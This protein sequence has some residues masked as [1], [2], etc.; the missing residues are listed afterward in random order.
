VINK[1]FHVLGEEPL[2]DNVMVSSD[3]YLIGE[4]R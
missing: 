1:H 3:L 2:N 4:Y